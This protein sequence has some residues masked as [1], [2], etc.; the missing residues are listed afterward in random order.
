MNID[1][2]G[3]AN[4][5]WTAFVLWVP[6]LLAAIIVL[7]IGWI[8]AAIL[9]SL[10]SSALVRVGLNRKVFESPA[11][12]FIRRLT[13][14]PARAI[15]R[16]VYWLV[17]IVTITI[18]IGTLE[19]PVL[20]NLVN[21][22]YGYIPNLLSAII[23]AAIGLGFSALVSGFVLRWMG[24]TPTGKVIASVVPIIVISITGFAILEQLKF[25]PIVVTATYIAIIGSLSLGLALAFGIGGS[26]AAKQMIDKAYGNS[27]SAVE[28]AKQDVQKGRERA[29]A[30]AKRARRNQT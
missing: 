17:M 19:I 6:R 22:I 14:D 2:G 30:D 27:G 26:N 21:S 25:A 11:D 18:V 10:T 3:E 23:I 5:I 15:G 12:S 1:F 16:F 13:H 4:L 24:D 8:I 7:I 20:T 29:E 28:Q 9:G